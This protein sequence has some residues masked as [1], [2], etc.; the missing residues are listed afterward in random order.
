MKVIVKVLKVLQA[1][2]TCDTVPDG[3]H[4]IAAARAPTARPCPCGNIFIS[5][6]TTSATARLRP[7]AAKEPRRAHHETLEYFE[8]RRRRGRLHQHQVSRA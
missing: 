3:Q 5:A 7:A 2:V 1:L 4:L 6:R 8:I